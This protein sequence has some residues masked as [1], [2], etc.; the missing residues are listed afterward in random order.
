MA[1]SST[2]PVGGGGAAERPDRRAGIT[3]LTGFVAVGAHAGALGL[4]VGFL[5]LGHEIEQRLPFGSPVLGGIALLLWVALPSTWSAWLAWHDDVLTDV[6]VLVNGF[7]LV[8]WILVQL[9]FI[10]ELSLFHPVYLAIGVA[11][12]FLGRRGLTDMGI[13]SGHRA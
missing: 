2:Q 9:A 12:I 11:L 10:R 13:T 7:L 3:L 6:A 8:A 1:E 5:S 4:I